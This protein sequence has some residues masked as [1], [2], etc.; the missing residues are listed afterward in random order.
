MDKVVASIWRKDNDLLQSQED[1]INL[2]SLIE[3]E[4]RIILKIYHFKC[5]L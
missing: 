2:A 5:F 3:A 1:L 4:A